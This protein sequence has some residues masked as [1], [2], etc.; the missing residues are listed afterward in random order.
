MV[1][2][3]GRGAALTA[4]Q[5]HVLGI[6]DRKKSTGN[7][8]ERWAEAQGEAQEIKSERKAAKSQIAC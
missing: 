6:F 3:W 5:S 8:T 7:R 2:V 4:A 1:Q